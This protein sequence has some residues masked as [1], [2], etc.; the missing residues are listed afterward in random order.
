MHTFITTACLL[1]LAATAGAQSYESYDCSQ[2]S[3]K[4]ACETAKDG[5][6]LVCQF[7]DMSSMCEQRQQ[8]NCNAQFDEG[9]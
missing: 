4:N 6:K 3:N 9:S 1:S 8:A 7:Q 5:G 2:H